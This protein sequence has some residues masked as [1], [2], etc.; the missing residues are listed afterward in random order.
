MNDLV[1]RPSFCPVTVE[2]AVIK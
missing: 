2:F 1:T